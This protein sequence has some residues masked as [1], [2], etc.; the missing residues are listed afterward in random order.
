MLQQLH[1]LLGHGTR[2]STSLQ[3]LCPWAFRLSAMHIPRGLYRTE[4]EAPRNVCILH[5][6]LDSSSLFSCRDDLAALILA[7]FKSVLD[8]QVSHLGFRHFV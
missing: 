2:L 5:R 8:R 6:N 3:A 4:H 7:A 1:A